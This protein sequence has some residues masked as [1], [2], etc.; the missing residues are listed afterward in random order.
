[1]PGSSG[2]TG[3][4]PVAITRSS[5]GSTVSPPDS[6]PRAVTVPAARSIADHLRVEPQS[7]PSARCS[8]GERAISASISSTTPPTKYGMPHAL[9]DV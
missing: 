2:R 6:R 8:S 1:M 5:K 4:A 7:M 3:V 9:Y